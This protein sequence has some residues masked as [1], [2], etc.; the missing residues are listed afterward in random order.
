MQITGR[1]IVLV[2]HGRLVAEEYFHGYTRDDLHE[3]QSVTK[4]VTSLLIG[5]AR[6]RGEIGELDEPVLSWFPAYAETAGAG[7]EK[8]TLRHLLTM[9]A[10]LG[11][12]RREAIKGPPVKA[13]PRSAPGPDAAR[14]GGSTAAS[15]R[16][17][18]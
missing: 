9:T 7:W 12:E 6:D 5:I 4:S 11:W 15:S 13:D 18:L 2:R 8:V 17:R 14:W 3:L 10:G 1:G 16:R